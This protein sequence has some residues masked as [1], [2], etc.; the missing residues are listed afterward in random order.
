M[1]NVR[2]TC[3]ETPKQLAAWPVDFGLLAAAN[4]A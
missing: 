3:N 4:L 2:C 1:L